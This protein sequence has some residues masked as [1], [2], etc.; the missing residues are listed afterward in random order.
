[1]NISQGMLQIPWLSSLYSARENTFMGDDSW[2]V[3][4]P[5]PET[6][7]SEKVLQR[8]DS[9]AMRQMPFIRGRLKIL[10]RSKESHSD[11]SGFLFRGLGVCG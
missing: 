5:L 4:Q 3:L 9:V 11:P 7:V 1:M 8:L 6:A 10:S 2:G